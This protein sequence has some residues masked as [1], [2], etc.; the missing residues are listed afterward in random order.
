MV[1]NIVLLYKNIIEILFHVVLYNTLQW[2]V[3]FASFD[4]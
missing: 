3:I 4:Y 2:I 1:D